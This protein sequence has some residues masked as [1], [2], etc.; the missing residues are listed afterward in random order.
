VCSTFADGIGLSL[1]HHRHHHEIT[2]IIII[3]FSLI[4]FVLSWPLAFPQVFPYFLQG[5]LLDITMVVGIGYTK[6]AGLTSGCFYFFIR[7]SSLVFSY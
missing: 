2:I 5:P 7:S 6:Y 1:F 3:V 4:A